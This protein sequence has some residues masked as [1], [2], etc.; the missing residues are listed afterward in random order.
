M[1]VF[2]KVLVMP[3]LAML[4]ILIA[5]SLTIA[6]FSPTMYTQAKDIIF[7]KV[8]FEQ[9]TGQTD[10]INKEYLDSWLILNPEKQQGEAIAHE[11][12]LLEEQI[13]TPPN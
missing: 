3:F 8:D 2:V 9:L 6:N 7:E 10:S 11:E 1:G 5:A 4:V 12:M 13:E